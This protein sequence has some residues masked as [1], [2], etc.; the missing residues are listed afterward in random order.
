[1]RIAVIDDERLIRKDL[2]NYIK[3]L[4]P[5]AVISEAENGEEAVKLAT[6]NNFDI[7]FLDI[8]LGDMNG[9]VLA[10]MLEKITP[11]TAVIFVT[12]YNEYAA[13]A[14]ELNAVDYVMKPFGKNRVE[15]ALKKAE[16]FLQMS[17]NK[18]LPLEISS[19]EGCV[20]DYKENEDT[21]IIRH[22]KAVT[23]LK[24]EDIVFV[25]SQ[26]RI[27]RVCCKDGQIYL[28]NQ[29]L[30]E[31]IH[32]LNPAKFMRIHKSFL[33]NLDYVLEIAPLYSKN[34]C[35]RVRGYE[36]EVLPVGRNQIK[37]LREIYHF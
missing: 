12:A 26:L 17:K 20:T 13:K 9:T 35:V 32:K 33:I 31:F 25:E 22:G 16:S 1:M 24:T 18:G 14:F 30:S 7:F 6:E 5:D 8:N 15:K 23:I 3:E 28:T 4:T 2:I 10:M 19:R 21:I 27:C 37:Q 36:K 11:E 34:Y 29:C